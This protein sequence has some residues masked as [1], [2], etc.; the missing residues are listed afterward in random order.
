MTETYVCVVLIKGGGGKIFSFSTFPKSYE[1]C[2]NRL[3]KQ[4]FRHKY[5]RS[6][7]KSYF[8]NVLFAEDATCCLFVFNNHWRVFGAL[9]LEKR[10]FIQSSLLRISHINYTIANW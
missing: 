10:E 5:E 3:P 8:G 9:L 4:C 6:I 7:F 2:E 1:I